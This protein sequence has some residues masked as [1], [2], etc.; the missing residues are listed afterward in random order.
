[1][2]V[3]VGDISTKNFAHHIFI[4]LSLLKVKNDNLQS[5]SHHEEKPS[6]YDKL[7]F[8]AKLVKSKKSK[9]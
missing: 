8:V 1:M 6:I 2:N 9:E 4:H 5:N 3:I 7:I